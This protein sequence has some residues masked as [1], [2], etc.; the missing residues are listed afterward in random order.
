[1]CTYHMCYVCILATMLVI[2]QGSS[3]RVYT[4]S[5]DCHKSNKQFQAAILIIHDLFHHFMFFMDRRYFGHRTSIFIM[6][7]QYQH[8]FIEECHISNAHIFVGFCFDFVISWFL[9]VWPELFTNTPDSRYIMVKYNAT[10]DT[11]L[12]AGSQNFVHTMNSQKSPHTSSLRASYGVSLMKCFEQSD[13][14]ISGARC[15]IQVHTFSTGAV[16]WLPQCQ[17]SHPKECG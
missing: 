14:V 4:R 6:C 7:C 9:A 12:M 11:I 15:I 1:M 10:L 16:A 8:Q 13:R 5:D 3:K 2:S 17:W